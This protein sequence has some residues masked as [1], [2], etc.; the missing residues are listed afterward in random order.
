MSEKLALPAA[1]RAWGSPSF[2][3]VLKRELASK[4]AH[5]PLQQALAHSSSVA[6]TPITVMVEGVADGGK[7][8]VGIFYEGIV[9]GCSC[10]D[11]PTPNNLNAEYCRL[12]LEIDT[13]TAECSVSLAGTD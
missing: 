3:E 8:T 5:L 12:L 4:A 9:A 10:A 7:A 2:A 6:E 11:D 1:A 13:D